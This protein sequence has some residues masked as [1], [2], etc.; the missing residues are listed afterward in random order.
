MD[1]VAP[2]LVHI[3]DGTLAHPAVLLRG[4][5]PGPVAPVADAADATARI[6]C[7]GGGSELFGNLA[8][9]NSFAAGNAVLASLE[10]FNMDYVVGPLVLHGVASDL[11]LEPLLQ[12]VNPAVMRQLRN[13]DADSARDAAA[14]AQSFVR[15]QSAHVL[16]EFAVPKLR[17]ALAAPQCLLNDGDLWRCLD[18]VCERIEL[19]LKLASDVKTLLV[20]GSKIYAKLGWCVDHDF[21][22]GCDAGDCWM[23]HLDANG[24]ADQDLQTY[25]VR[26][27]RQQARA[28]KRRLL[29]R[30]Q[31]PLPSQPP[32]A[33]A[34]EA[35]LKSK[36]RVLDILARTSDQH[37]GYSGE[38]VSSMTATIEMR[39]DK[40]MAVHSGAVRLLFDGVFAPAGGNLARHFWP[41]EIFM[42]TRQ[43]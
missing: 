34:R 10:G 41:H 9:G 1:Q 43:A 11:S 2:M 29:G 33:A 18:G 28:L 32:V 20:C 30:P 4:A 17:D 15:A 7:G 24:V 25:G 16:C 23:K 37:L 19:T 40:L 38:T 6:V 22:G 42:P 21:A 36:A 27:L 5:A 39:S 8:R 31:A 35:A 12:C 14:I 26:M 13:L 3:R